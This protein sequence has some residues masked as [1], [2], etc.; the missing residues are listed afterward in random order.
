MRTNRIFWAILLVGLGFLFLANN[1]GL[2]DVNV[3][4]LIW[5]AFLIFLGISFLLGTTRR[6]DAVTLEQGSIDLDGAENATVRVKHGAGRLI[7]DDSAES[8]KLASGTFAHGLDARVKRDGNN[9][10][11]VMQPKSPV[12]P[13]VVFP[14]NWTSTRGFRW[15]FGFSRGVP[16]NLIFETGAA[17]ANLDLTNLQVKDLKLS[18]GASSTELKLPAGAGYTQVKVEAGAASIIIRVPDGVAARIEAEAGLAS[19]SVDQ[20]RF[21][22]GNGFYQSVDYQ[23]A[24][25]KADIRIETGMASIEIV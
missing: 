2:M 20:S 25:N 19:I 18:T 7:V 9:L 17:E 16:L 23:E 11:V 24:V 5:P 4:G 15:E 21:P 12:F 14:W 3:W 6:S 22:K 13:D 1:L 8:G 10:E